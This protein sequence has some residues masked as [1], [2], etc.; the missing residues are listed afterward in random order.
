MRGLEILPVR[1][2]PE[3]RPGDDLPYLV[4]LSEACHLGQLATTRENQQAI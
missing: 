2:I 3:V 4:S 1:G